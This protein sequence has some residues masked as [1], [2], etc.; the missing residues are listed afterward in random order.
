MVFSLPGTAF[1]EDWTP[2]GSSDS[3]VEDSRPLPPPDM[4]D[5]DLERHHHLDEL[6]DDVERVT[7]PPIGI[8]PGNL[9]NPNFFQ[10]PNGVDPL[11]IGESQFQVFQLG[12]GNSAKMPLDPSKTEPVEIK[13]IVLT[14][15]T[16]SD[17]FLNS[18]LAWG[19]GLATTAFGLLAF[20]SMNSLRLRKK[21][22]K[23]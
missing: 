5:R 1:A 13:N 22:K 15:A 18:A 23:Q 10:L 4:D 19:V 2:E 12:N 3:E 6:Y 16:P 7:L 11:N 17:E 14:R 21:A 8:K 9:P 20:A